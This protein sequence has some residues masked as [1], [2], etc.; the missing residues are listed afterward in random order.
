MFGTGMMDWIA[1]TAT[2]VV[3]TCVPFLLGYWLDNRKKKK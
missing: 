3:V 1:T 2:G